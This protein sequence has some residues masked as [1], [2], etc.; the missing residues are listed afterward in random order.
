MGPVVVLGGAKKPGVKEAVAASRARLEKEFGVVAVDLEGVLDLSQ[1][2]AKWA[3]VFGGD[4]A[5]LSAGR[6][7]GPCS[8]RPACSKTK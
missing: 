5:I 8:P 6:L 1:L 2:D 7:V 4:G 3:L